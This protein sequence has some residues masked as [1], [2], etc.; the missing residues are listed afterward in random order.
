MSPSLSWIW[1]Y[2]QGRDVSG[3]EESG[4]FSCHDGFFDASNTRKDPS[5]VTSSITA[6]T[7][8]TGLLLSSRASGPHKGCYDHAPRRPC[9]G[10]FSSSC[11]DFIET[12][13]SVHAKLKELH[14]ELDQFPAQSTTI[15]R[16]L[17]QQQQQQENS[18]AMSS[19]NNEYLPSLQVLML[20]SE[21]WVV[22]KAAARFLRFLDAKLQ[23]FGPKALCRPLSPTMTEVTTKS[24]AAPGFRNGRSVHNVDQVYLWSGIFQV[25]EA[26]EAK[27]G[28]C[29]LV[30]FPSLVET[31][32]GT[33]DALSLVDLVRGHV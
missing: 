23:W 26:C 13:Q 16:Y 12:P 5:A 22:S 29:V 17:Q 2:L 27:Q 21:Q 3:L 8:T 9:S 19:T 33:S 1:T 14:A 7:E 11:S 24:A 6:P 28:R 31:V 25:L 4:S 32:M 10:S 20:R 30:I 15:Y 18:T